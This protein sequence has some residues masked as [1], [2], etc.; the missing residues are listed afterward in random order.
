MWISIYKDKMYKAKSFTFTN[1]LPNSMH[2]SS[3]RYSRSINPKMFA[4]LAT[5]ETFL[6]TNT[7]RDGSGRIICSPYFLHM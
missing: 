7:L 1:V 5:H 4:F 2:V 3:C 6:S